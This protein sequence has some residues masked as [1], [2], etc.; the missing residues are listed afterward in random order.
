ME[1]IKK[2][3]KGLCALIT[4]AAMSLSA[5]AVPA[6]ASDSGSA[7]AIDVYVTTE[8]KKQQVK[9]I[10]KLNLWVTPLTPLKMFLKK[11]QKI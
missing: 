5:L 3:L 7:N 4:A 11:P 10:A 6:M 8:A 2:R 9:R 1:I